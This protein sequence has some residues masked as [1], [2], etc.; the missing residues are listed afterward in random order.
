TYTPRA[1]TQPPKKG[2]EMSHDPPFTADHHAVAPLQP[3]HAAARPDIDIVDALRRQLL[4]AADVV[5]VIGIAAVD[6][7]VA[8]V[9]SGGDAGDRLV[10]D[11]CGHHQPDDSWFLQLLDEV[12][13]RSGG[14]GILFGH[15]AYRG[16]RHVEDH[17][18]VA[19]F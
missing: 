1:G 10:D 5:D 11:A 17:A 14:N 16:C 15:F 6:Q 4:G 13:K 9:E 8:G 12:G 7:D 2:V 19:R 18:V 3:P